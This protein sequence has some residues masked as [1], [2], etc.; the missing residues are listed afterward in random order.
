MI[1]CHSFVVLRFHWSEKS[2][3]FCTKAP[4]WTKKTLPQCYHPLTN[5][6]ERTSQNLDFSTLDQHASNQTWGGMDQRV[7]AAVQ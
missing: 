1:N 4:L 5:V 2:P 7:R 3:Y 6:S